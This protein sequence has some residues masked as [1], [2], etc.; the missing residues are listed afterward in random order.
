MRLV[1]TNLQLLVVVNLN[2]RYSIE[3]NALMS[4][5]DG[6]RLYV[7]QEST[8]QFMQEGV[9]LTIEEAAT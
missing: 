7:H 9:V 6:K 5:K 3:N 4:A 1:A 2:E 8:V